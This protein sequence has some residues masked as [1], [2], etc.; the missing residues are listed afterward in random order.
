MSEHPT[1]ATNPSPPVSSRHETGAVCAAPG[2]NEPIR[3]QRTGRPARFCSP[4][5]RARSHRTRHALTDTPITVEVD[6]GSASSRGRPAGTAWMVRLRR[7]DKAVIVAIGLRRGAADRLAEQLT[8]LVAT[9]Q[10]GGP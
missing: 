2:C 1:T 7:G 5:C 6:Y 9:P 10:P 8:D 4:A 3:R